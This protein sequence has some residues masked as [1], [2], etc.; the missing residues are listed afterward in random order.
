M[1]SYVLLV[2]IALG[3]S[4][5]VYNYLSN[6][7]PKD[8]PACPEDIALSVTPVFCKA[9]GGELS[10]Q[11]ANKGLFNIDLIYVRLAKE[12]RT[13][14]QNI[15]T[16]NEILKPGESKTYTKT[17]LSEISSV[18]KYTLEVQ[19]GVLVKKKL[20]ICETAV[21]TVQITCS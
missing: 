18:G 7:V 1:V 10:F 5:L 4:I 9:T 17:G 14:A 11:Y 20:A 21:S 8:R 15:D 6:Y 3:L 2:V 13:V 12:N 16:K 19:P